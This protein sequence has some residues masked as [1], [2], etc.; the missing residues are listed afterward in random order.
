MN[1]LSSNAVATKAKAMY[2]K[3]LRKE[4]YQEML[5]KRSVNEVAAYLKNETAYGDIL[6]GVRENAIHRSQLE[7]LLKK[8][9]YL[10]SQKLANF[11]GVQHRQF[12][13]YLVRL[14]EIDQIMNCIH[15]IGDDDRED[16]LASIPS[17][18]GKRTRFD[19]LALGNV[20]HFDDLLYVLRGTGY[21]KILAEFKPATSSDKIDTLGCERA[22]RKDYYEKLFDVIRRSYKGTLRKQLLEIFETGLELENVSRI[23]RLKK[24][25]HA[26]PSLISRTLIPVHSRLSS[27]FM[28]ELVQAPSDKEML[29]LLSESSYQFYVGEKDYVFIEYYATEI[30]YHLSE[31]YMRFSTVAPLVYATY[32]SLHNIEIENII[33]IIEGVR[34][35]V[36]PES[37]EEVLIY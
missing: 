37:I 24:Y 31:R 30:K 20:H 2:G 3:R 5:R 19:F 14:S 29:R 21:D 35:H 16:Y 32:I 15:A 22:L 4:D 6:D 12:Y 9:L 13:D 27:S 36:S 11:A 18:L 1:A 8:D 7:H 34:Y 17:Y 28:D 33:H 10:K 23:Y 25:F 26:D